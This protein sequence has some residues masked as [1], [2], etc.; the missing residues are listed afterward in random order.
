MESFSSKE[1]RKINYLISEYEWLYHELALKFNLT[2]S[3]MKILYAICDIGEPTQIKD[4]CKHTATSK[5]TINSALR[6]LEIE[7]IIY[8][9]FSNGK[10]KNV[11]LTDKGK[12]LVEKTV[13][14]IILIENE[15]FNSWSKEELEVYFRLLEKYNYQFKDKIKMMEEI[16]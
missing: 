7:N 12:L 2:D 9:K 8:L 1:L 10:S 15:I 6:K 5:Q 3:S 16:K 14:K 4:I 13:K 11:F